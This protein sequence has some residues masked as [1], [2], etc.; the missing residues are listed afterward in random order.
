[1]WLNLK[2]GRLLGACLL[3]PLFSSACGGIPAQVNYC[4]FCP[5]FYRRGV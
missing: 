3:F 4:L 5:F 1:M 2:N